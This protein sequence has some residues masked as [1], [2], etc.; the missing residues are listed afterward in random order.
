MLIFIVFVAFLKNDLN[1]EFFKR[2]LTVFGLLLLIF[3][4]DIG[5]KAPMQ[6]FALF[7]FKKYIINS[8]NI[9]KICLLFYNKVF[10]IIVNYFLFICFKNIINSDDFSINFIIFFLKV[11]N[12]EVYA[13]KTLNI[14]TISLDE[15]TA[16]ISFLIYVYGMVCT[17]TNF[18][19]M[20]FNSQLYQDCTR[21]AKNAMGIFGIN[22]IILS[23]SQIL[24]VLG[25]FFYM[26]KKKQI[27]FNL[28]VEEANL[29]Q[30]M[31]IF[32]ILFNSTDNAFQNYNALNSM[33][34]N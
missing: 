4:H 15:W 19:S 22:E 3:I 23:C 30:R 14:L 18:F 16:W 17:Y 21:K 26:I 20:S 25:I 12:V 10:V 33:S 34:S 11:V 6:A 29:F 13:V 5:L 8:L 7:F 27:M 24:M 28:Q 9:Y 31:L 1:K 2:V 32:F